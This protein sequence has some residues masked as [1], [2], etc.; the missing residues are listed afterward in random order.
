MKTTTILFLML[1]LLSSLVIAVPP[2]QTVASSSVEGLIIE[3]PLFDYHTIN[4]N[5]NFHA[6]VFNESNGRYMLNDTIDCFIH[7]Y[8]H[9]GDHILKDEMTF[10][11]PVD[12]EYM[13]GG[14]NFSIQGHYAQIIFCNSTNLG[15][16]I[17]I[18]FDVTATGREERDI[19]LALIVGIGIISALL[20]FLAVK[21]DEEHGILKILLIISSVTLL[22]LIPISTFITITSNTGRIFYRTFLYIFIVFWLYVFIYFTYWIL[23]KLG[24]IA[25]GEEEE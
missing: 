6:H 4:E 17:E 13:V 1:I 19:T 25:S 9:A 23:K 10:E 12:F 20:L 21:L 24:I 14:E 11:P 15:G 7:L 16:A 18:S 5:F 3:V 2:V 22:I 8:N